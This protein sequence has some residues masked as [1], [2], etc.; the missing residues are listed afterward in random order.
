MTIF[1]G[2]REDLEER[3][4]S[5]DKTMRKPPLAARS[6]Y[7]GAPSWAI[8]IAWQIYW[9]REEVDRILALLRRPEREIITA[10]RDVVTTQ[11]EPTG[12]APQI[13]SEETTMPK[14]LTIDLIATAVHTIS[15]GLT[16]EADGTA[17]PIPAGE[18][19]AATSPSPA[20]GVV[21]DNTADTMTINALTLPSANT[22]S[23][24]FSVTDSNNDVAL[25]VTVNYPVP[26]VDDITS[27]GDVVTAQP[28]PTAPGP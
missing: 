8:E 28:A 19:F 13:N 6:P 3:V 23:M 16:S 21:I 22:A 2:G 17:V 9:L 5:G 20:I 10:T 27:T 14:T 18:T 24:N 7:A 15:L 4:S 12:P 26:V 11:P 1:D 25:N